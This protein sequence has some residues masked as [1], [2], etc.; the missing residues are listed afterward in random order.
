[1][2]GLGHVGW[3]VA[4]VMVAFAGT[5]AL[6][7][8]LTR[9]PAPSQTAQ[10]ASAICPTSG[11]RASL[12]RP[13]AMSPG[14]SAAVSSYY[15]LQFTNVSHQ[16]CSV[17]GYPEVSAFVTRGTA[18]MPAGGPSLGSSVA[19]HDPSVRPRRVRLEPGE[20]A[21]ALLRITDTG[22][23]RPTTCVRVTSEELR[24]TLPHQGRSAFVPVHIPL[25][26]TRGHISFTVQAL[27]ARSGVSGY[28]VP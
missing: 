14:R 24:V 15:T 22:S 26:S 12:G 17:F 25:C 3:R 2:T 1:M 6:A 9:A 16:A 20:T 7:V 18:T 28:T 27:Q 4:A 13:A 23:A 8:T 19:A 11:L 21:Q 10:T 5:A